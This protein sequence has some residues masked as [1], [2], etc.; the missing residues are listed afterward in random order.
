[1]VT[2]RQLLV[3]AVECHCRASVTA[4]KRRTVVAD[5]RNLV[6][7][8]EPCLT[9]PLHSAAMV[10]LTGQFTCLA[11]NC[12]NI[13]LLL[14][15]LLRLFVTCKVP[16]RRPQMRYPAVTKCSCLYT[17]YHRNNNVFS[18]VLKVVRLQ[19]DIRNVQCSICSC[20]TF[21]YLSTSAG[22][23]LNEPLS[24][25][26]RQAFSLLNFLTALFLIV[27]VSPTPISRPFFSRHL[28]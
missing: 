18:C 27:T 9:H 15:L 13:E 12:E 1:M 7:R 16:S 23:S 10:T 22:A 2:S 21:Q 6:R 14:L 8:R 20:I 24:S 25:P 11:F 19:S 28:Q 5:R 3:R 4:G 17:M 26:E